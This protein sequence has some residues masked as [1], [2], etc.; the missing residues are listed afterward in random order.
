MASMPPMAPAGSKMRLLPS[1]AA[2]LRRP[3]ASARPARQ[4]KSPADQP[5]RT[6]LGPVFIDRL[7]A[8][9]FGDDLGRAPA[10]RRA[11]RRYRCRQRRARL[12]G[13]VPAGTARRRFHAAAGLAQG[14]QNVLRDAAVTDQSN[15]TS[16]RIPCAGRFDQPNSLAGVTGY[17]PMVMPNGDSAS[18][19]A[20]TI[21]PAAGTQ[22]DSPTPLTP[23]GLSGDGDSRKCSSIFGNSVA[24]RQADSRRRSWS[25][26]ARLRRSPSIRTAHCRCRARRRRRVGLR[27]SWD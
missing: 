11:I 7:L 19:I 17:P 22:P 12:I 21:A 16:R 8:G 25:A 1:F 10:N 13:R 3:A 27:R 9:D 4:W 15:R 6:K 2:T 24:L 20:A 5:R 18:S 14:R 23:S 26:A